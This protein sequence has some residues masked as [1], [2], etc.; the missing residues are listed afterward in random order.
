MMKT[1]QIMKSIR[2][3]IL[4]VIAGSMIAG[5]MIA[6]CNMQPRGAEASE[7]K[8]VEQK[9]QPVKVMDLIYRETGFEQNVTSTV[10]AFEET[11]LSPALQ[12]RIRTVKV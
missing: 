7:S 12:G 5:S 6:G 3:A 10:V 2:I 11:Y 8:V 1:I 4:S 9:I